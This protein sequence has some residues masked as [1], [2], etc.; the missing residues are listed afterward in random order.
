MAGVD[1]EEF[2]VRVF[3]TALRRDVGHSAFENLQ[4]RL[5]D[6]LPG[7]VTGDGRVLVFAA[8]LVNLVNVDDALLALLYISPGRLQQFEDNVFHVL[9]DIPCFGEGRGVDDGK[10]H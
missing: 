8:D 10:R 3:A 9:A 2:L 7:H 4:Q 5:L 6:A 1:L